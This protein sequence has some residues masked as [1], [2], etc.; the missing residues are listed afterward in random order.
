MRSPE[1]VEGVIG[2]LEFRLS[3]EEIA[4][5]DDFRTAPSAML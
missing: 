2:A 4:E 3:N 5:V 1:Q